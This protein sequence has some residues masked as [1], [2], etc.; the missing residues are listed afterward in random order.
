MDAEQYKEW[1]QKLKL[2]DEYDHPLPDEK[3][4]GDMSA[5]LDNAF[6]KEKKRRII[7][8]FIMPLLVVPVFFFISTNNDVASKKTMTGKINTGATG[9][10]STQKTVEKSQIKVA[11][12][13]IETEDLKKKSGHSGGFYT[14]AKGSRG[15]RAQYK[16]ATGITD[17]VVKQQVFKQKPIIKNSFADL[18]IKQEPEHIETVLQKPTNNTASDTGNYVQSETIS[19]PTHLPVSSINAADTTKAPERKEQTKWDTKKSVPSRFYLSA[20]IAPNKS[21]VASGDGEWTTAY[22]GSVGYLLGEKWFIEGGVF[23]GRALYSA[24]PE[25]YKWE[26]VYGYKLKSVAANCFIIEIPI[27]VGYTLYE[28]RRLQIF[29]T[30]GISSQ[31]MKQEDYDYIAVRDVLIYKGTWT[32]KNENKHF[33]SAARVSLGMA[34]KISNKLAL[35]AAPYFKKSLKGVGEGEV[36][37]NS[38]GINFNLQY[39]PFTKRK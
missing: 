8:F 23:A 22:G 30:A 7:W 37:L 38:S 15:D 39:F 26:G 9:N 16:K 2:A 1:E 5:K 6:G 10:L 25:D 18:N 19:N 36:N 32:Y 29:S 28:N 12:K 3:A 4:W 35:Q 27:N 34:Y 20:S 11:E 21:F 24:G 13:S 31:I 14:S 17:H 33:I